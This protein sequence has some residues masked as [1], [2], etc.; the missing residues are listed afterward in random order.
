[1]NTEAIFRPAYLTGQELKEAWDYGLTR[2]EI[3]Y[4][5]DSSQAEELLFRPNFISK[6]SQDIE[7]VVLAMNVSRVCGYR[8]PILRMMESFQEKAKVCQL[9]VQ[10]PDKCALVYAKGIK[11]NHYCG[12]FKDIPRQYQFNIKDFLASNSLPGPFSNIHCIIYRQG[13]YG[14]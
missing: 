13:L 6:A 2:I 3:S 14:S 5:A 11:K 9:F 7:A 10:M 12:F 1:M 8:I 4:Y